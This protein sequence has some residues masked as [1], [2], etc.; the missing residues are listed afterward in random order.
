MSKLEVGAD[1]RRRCSKRDMIH[2][3][4]YIP[5]TTRNP[6]SKTLSFSC[7]DLNI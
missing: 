4:Y 3:E 7:V 1:W 6:V 5:K 2:K